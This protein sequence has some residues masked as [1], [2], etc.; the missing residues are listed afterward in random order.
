MRPFGAVVVV[1]AALG[2]G[3][4]TSSPVDE[5]ASIGWRDCAAVTDVG[6]ANL[7]SG[8]FEFHCGLVDVDLDPGRK[9][10][11]TVA[12]QLIRVHRSGGAGS[13]D[14]LLLI[15]GGP[16]QS[17]VDYAGVAAGLL[18]DA[19]LDRFDLIGFDPRGVG[20]SGPIRCEHVDSGPPKFPDLLSAAGYAQAAGEMREG[21]EEC[22]TPLGAKAALF[23]TTATAVDIDRI[24]SVLG[25]STLTYVGWSYGAKLGAEYARLYP[26]KV[27]AAVLDA[28]SN[29]RTTWIET[30][31]RQ[32]AGFEHAFDQFTAWC[33][34]Q[35]RCQRFGAVRS[36]V[37]DLVRKAQKSPISSGRPGDDVPT[38]GPDIIDAVVAALYD[39]DR[40]PD[41]ADGLAEAADGDSGTLRDLADAVRGDDK[42]SNAT[43]ANFV[44]NC[45]DSAAGP[46]EAE[47]KAA[48][49]R[50]ARQFPLFGVWGSWQLFG[51]SFW[52][53]PRHT[54][55]PPVA[56]TPHPIVVVGTRHDP[57]TPYSGAVAMAKSLGTAELL[58]W[59]GEGHTA[60]GRSDCITRLVADYLV[61][62]TVP[63]H[64][65]HCPA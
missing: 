30:A 27:R 39:D 51:C 40:W 52:Q 62:L 21:T 15:A 60:V 28:P 50:F 31:E 57:A 8:R 43:D 23:S 9:E 42:D 37:G 65:T 22:A 19:V 18:P 12:V 49:A 35:A 41:L 55:Q 7:P 5:S 13:K 24:R 16:G 61:S 45:N 47:I 14:P 3:S 4:C 34:T 36:F 2:L 46:T 58:T 38:Y 59:E 63:P 33:A 64:D 6:A 53:P 29:P 54:V 20:H 11:G 48:G 10:A 56:A 44:I 26:D 17:G 25:Q 32:V 1:A